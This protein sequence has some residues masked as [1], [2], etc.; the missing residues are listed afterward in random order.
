MGTEPE[1]DV[2]FV[3]VHGAVPEVYGG[4]RSTLAT[5]SALRARGLTPRFLLTADDDLGRAVAAAGLEYEI[6]PVGDPFDGIRRASWRGRV[7]KLRGLLRVNAAGFRRA[8]RARRRA[9]IHTAGIPAFFASWLGGRLAGAKVIFHV[10]GASRNSV[11]RWYES[12][13]ILLADRTITVSESLRRQLLDTG[14]AWARP[15]LAPRTE[16]IYS[17]FD[18]HEMDAFM[19]RTSRA[20]ARARLAMPE[21]ELNL[22]LVGGISRDKG[23]L[24]LIEEALPAAFAAVPELCITFIGGSKDDA[25]AAA[26]H[27]ALRRAGLAGRA[28]FTGYQPLEEVYWHLRAAD[29]LVLP[30]ERE[31]LP[32]NAIEGHG[33]GLPVVATAIIGS[34]E[35]VRHGESGF[36]VPN[37]RVGD[38]AEP[39]VTLA[40]DPALRARMGAAGAAHVRASFGMDRHVQEIARVYRELL[41]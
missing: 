34:V 29:V 9:I 3:V 16:A 12:V 19:A 24:R 39:L 6:V 8:A 25:Y 17:G 33:F 26:C 35:V 23:Q 30:S 37:D 32:R 20:A 41:S 15:L 36:L 40:R 5:A 4:E 13:A 22:L 27:A 1:A 21:G 14:A 18:F 11:T 31:G 38:M 28:R 10:R 2:T 7:E